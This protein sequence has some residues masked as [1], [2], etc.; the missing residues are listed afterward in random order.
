MQ[1]Y[2]SLELAYWYI[3]MCKTNSTLCTNTKIQSFISNVVSNMRSIYPDRQLLSDELIVTNGKS[4][5]ADSYT[6]LNVNGDRN[7]RFVPPNKIDEINERIDLDQD[8]SEV[9]RSTFKSTL[10]PEWL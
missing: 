6:A 7:I 3:L 8:L 2:S 4:V 9:L 5:Y 1:L 10:T